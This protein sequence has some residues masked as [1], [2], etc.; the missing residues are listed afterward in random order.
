MIEYKSVELKKIDKNVFGIKECKGFNPSTNYKVIDSD[1]NIIS[2]KDFD[3]KK[4]QHLQ[5]IADGTEG[6]YLYYND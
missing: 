1:K 6:I 2:Y 4:S 5:E 3:P